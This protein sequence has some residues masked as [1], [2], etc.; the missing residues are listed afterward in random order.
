MQFMLAQVSVK[1]TLLQLHSQCYFK[2][3]RLKVHVETIQMDTKY[4]NMYIYLFQNVIAYINI[5]HCPED[6]L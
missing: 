6:T 4:F 1:Y 3:S 5:M 2:W